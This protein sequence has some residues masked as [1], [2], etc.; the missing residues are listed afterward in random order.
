MSSRVEAQRDPPT[1]C[2]AGKHRLTSTPK[3]GGGFGD[4]AAI[5]GAASTT[6][7]EPPDRVLSETEQ[8]E[9]AAL[10]NQGQGRRASG[11]ERKNIARYVAEAA[12]PPQLLRSVVQTAHLVP[13]EVGGGMSDAHAPPPL[14]PCP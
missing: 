11:R 12:P 8:L 1:H 2:G 13:S 9:L 7:P 5:G 6:A 4:A 3:S 10:I 14:L